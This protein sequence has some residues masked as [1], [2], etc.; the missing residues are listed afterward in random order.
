[1]AQKLSISLPDE[2][3]A[4]L[5]VY[6]RAHRLSSRSAAFVAAVKALRDT[7]LEAAYER[8]TLEWEGSEDQKLWDR[9]TADGLDLT[10]DWSDL[11][12]R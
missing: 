10:E 11:E 1:M 5:D 2:D 6:I 7:E 8:A 3:V 4:F 9:A 12:K